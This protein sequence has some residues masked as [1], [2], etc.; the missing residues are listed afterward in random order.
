MTKR[1][2]S[3]NELRQLKTYGYRKPSPTRIKD[4]YNGK[5]RSGGLQNDS[6]PL[7]THLQN[8]GKTYIQHLLIAWTYAYKLGIM[9]IIAFIHGILPFA[10]QTYVTDKIKEMR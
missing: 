3:L 9:A 2:R 5:T 6:K 10:F 8:H 1:K 4:Q 7:T